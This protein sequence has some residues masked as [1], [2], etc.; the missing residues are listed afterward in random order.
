MLL[1]EESVRLG[2][3]EGDVVDA[4]PD[5]GLRIRNVLRAQALIDRLPGF[6]AIVGTEGSRGRDGDVDAF[7]IRWIEQDAVKAHAA[8][9]RLP[10][11]PGAVTAKSGEFFP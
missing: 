1:H 7:R 6:S 11:R 2:F 4:M 10:L 3:V 9:A 5:L 8:S